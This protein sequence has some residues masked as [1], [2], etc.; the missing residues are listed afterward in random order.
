LWWKDEGEDGREIETEKGTWCVVA[1]GTM[2]SAEDAISRNTFGK[3][4]LTAL[5]AVFEEIVQAVKDAVA[6][7]DM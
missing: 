6:E 7:L 3:A 4:A 5:V 1:M 2:Q